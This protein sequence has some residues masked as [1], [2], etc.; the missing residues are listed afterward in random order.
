[1]TT[2]TYKTTINILNVINSSKCLS[3]E[4]TT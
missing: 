4:T 1:M 2:A 3:Q